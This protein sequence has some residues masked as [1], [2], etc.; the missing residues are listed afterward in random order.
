M[1]RLLTT[2]YLLLTVAGLAMAQRT[3][4]GTVTGDDGEAL[5]GAAVRLQGSNRGTLTDANG[6]FTLGGITD[7]GTLTFSYTGYE[8]QEVP[9]GASNVINVVLKSGTVLGETVVTALGITRSEK[10]LGYSV[11]K[12]DGGV[13][14]GSGEVNAI[15]GLAAKAAGIQV[16]GSGG[17]PGASSK[18]LIRG[19]SSLQ[20]NS[21]PLI[22][23]DN[24]PYDNTVNTVIGQDYPFNANLAGVNE[25][26]RGIDINPDDIESISVLKGPA[27]S[28]LYGTRAANGVLLIT[29]KKGRKG[30]DISYNAS[31]DLSEVNKLPDLQSAYGQGT[32]G[33]ASQLDANGQIIG[34]IGAGNPVAGTPNSWGPA[35]TES[36]D[37]Y[38]LYFQQGVSQ[39]HNVSVAGGN[40]N[41][42]FRVSYGNTNQEGIVPN[43]RLDRNSFSVN[44]TTG[45]DKF[46]VS[47]TGRY[48]RTSDLKAQ[49]GSNLS[50]VMLPLL[51]MPANF[52]VLGGTAANGYENLDGTQHTY[53]AIYDNP[54]WTAYQNPNTSSVGRLTG[55]VA[56]DY[57]PIDWLKFTF[58]IGTDQYNDR[59]VQIFNIGN[60][61]VDSRGEVWNA[62]SRYEEVNTDFLANI[63]KSFGKISTNVTLGSQLNRRENDNVFARGANLAVPN[64]FNL[65]NASLLYADNSLTQRRLAGVFFTA[66]IGYN[67][68]VYL[69]VGG[70]NDWAS[71]F[72]ADAKNS[73][74]YPNASLSFMLS[75]VL[76]ANNILSYAKLRASYAQAGREPSV[77]SSRTYYTRP[78]LTDGFTDG[79]SFPYLGQNGFAISNVLGNSALRPEI[80]T[81]YEGGIDLRFWG[82]RIRT[83]F[84]YYHS[85]STDLLVQRPIAS[86][87]GFS[88][89]NSNIGELENKG[90]EIEANIEVIKTKSFTWSV[91]G[92][93]TRNR[94]EVL[95]LA[96]GVDEF[97]VESAFTGIGSYAIVGQPYG[98]VY[99]TQW[100]RDAQ[101]RLI[102]GTNGLPR[103]AAEEGFLGNPYPDW[104]AGINSNLNFKGLSLSGLL[105]I[106]QGGI[107]WNGTW[108]RLNRIGRTQ[109]SGD[110]RTNF[111]V[112]EGVKDDGTPNDIRVNANRYFTTFKGDGGAYAVENAIQS[113]SWVRLREVTLSYQLPKF[114]KYVKGLSVY[115][116]GRNLWL[117]T[118][119]TGVDPETSLTGAGS[120][121]GGFDYFNMPST[122]SYIFGIRSNF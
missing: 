63:N 82:Q 58:R 89:F 103:V 69:T 25:S 116:T 15:Q 24:V 115:A 41:T 81:T 27:A 13:V 50:G 106:R 45:T 49:N 14:S 8:S 105:D 53:V 1:K 119:Y 38:D 3:V 37:N 117:N 93:F 121:I 22:V 71:T 35:L 73:F 83:S 107:L 74:F 108:A 98:A 100:Q 54:L 77:Y 70:R 48:T 36:F 18:I 40:E 29:T 118:D 19:N 113:G 80:N 96:P 6:A 101:G 31:L 57:L 66:D 97:S 111:Y 99:G 17:T 67:D 21:Q 61:N 33:G 26:N 68:L 91:G 87:S 86:T 72:G 10:A 104:T 114:S 11:T 47:A 112:I 88:N 44:A 28:A 109:E 78:T 110:G 84:T 64:F 7:G 42:T 102:I 30:L 4:T 9:V 39:N 52:N 92:N 59:R 95:K 16:V 51:R 85:I 20:L 122:R 12:V 75:E 60:N 94:N 90:I 5:A 65:N 55:S 79:N 23:V 120:S 76:P 2:L 43:T 56:F 32:G 46:K 62:N 34:S